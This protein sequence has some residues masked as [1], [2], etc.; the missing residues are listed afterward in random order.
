MSELNEKR[1]F[2]DVKM[3]LED[4]LFLY[5]VPKN[6]SF[7]VY[8]LLKKANKEGTIIVNSFIKEQLVEKVGLT[9]GTI[10]NALTK[11]TESLLLERLGRGAYRPHEALL[12]SRELSEGK[13]VGLQVDYQD[14]KKTI[15]ST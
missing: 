8:E 14:Q 6:L 1:N 12:K 7:L 4:L 9:K 10:D 11:L 13:S 15:K 2:N 5:Q 3:Y